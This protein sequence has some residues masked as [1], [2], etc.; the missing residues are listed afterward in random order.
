MD[1]YF[2]TRV[3]IPA[4]AMYFINELLEAQKSTDYYEGGEYVFMEEKYTYHVRIN[5]DKSIVL[6]KIEK[7]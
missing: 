4:D 3:G 1:I 6:H 7:A 5:R 2:R